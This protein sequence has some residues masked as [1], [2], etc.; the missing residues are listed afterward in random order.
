MLRTTRL[1]SAGLRARGP[2]LAASAIGGGVALATANSPAECLFSSKPKVHLRY[3]G[4]DGVAQT[5]RHVMALG[6]LEWTEDSWPIDFSK[7]GKGGPTVSM[8]AL[9]PLRRRYRLSLSTSCSLTRSPYP[10]Y[11]AASASRSGFAGLC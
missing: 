8:A 4:I 7:F 10:S 5:I 1:L 9:N 6:N 2:L 3:F 11:L